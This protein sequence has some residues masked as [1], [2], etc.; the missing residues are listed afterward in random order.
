M[1]L[2]SEST[3]KV[4]CVGIH[5][6]TGSVFLDVDGLNTLLQ[7]R[8]KPTA[9]KKIAVRITFTADRDAAVYAIEPAVLTSRP[10]MPGCFSAPETADRLN[11]MFPVY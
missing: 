4:K 3:G 9:E 5:K 7:W 10:F 2:S 1:T 8:F 11:Q 6:S